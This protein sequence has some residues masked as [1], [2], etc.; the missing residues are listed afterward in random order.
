[1]SL[2]LEFLRKPNCLPSKRPLFA[3]YQ[4]ERVV[5]ETSGD[6]FLGVSAEDA[7]QHGISVSQL[8]K[9]SAHSM[10]K[11]HWRNWRFGNRQST[12]DDLKNQKSHGHP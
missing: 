3:A 10:N 4:N 11:K 7:V 5:S 12:G 2:L 6:R 9:L 1:M 8:G